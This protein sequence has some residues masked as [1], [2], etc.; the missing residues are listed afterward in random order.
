MKIKSVKIKNFRSIKDETLIF[1]ENWLVSIIWPNNAWKSN[2]LRAIDLVLWDWYA[3]EWKLE[4]YDFY[5]WNRENEIYIQ[6]NFT[7]NPDDIE[8]F[9][10]KKE[11]VD[12]KAKMKFVWNSTEYFLSNEK[13]DK[14]P[15]TY[16]SAERSIS[17][18]TAFTKWSLMWKISKS[19]NK[20]INE[21]QKQALKTHFDWVKQIFSWVENFS[22]FESDFKQYFQE[23]QSD[24]PY[25]LDIDFKAFT[26]NNYFKSINI[27]ATDPN[28]ENN[29]D[30]EELWDWAK[31]LT[32]ISLLRSYAKN[33]R[34]ANGILA[35]EEPEI[36][37]HPQARKHLYDI[38][39]DLANSWVQV[40]YTTHDPNFLEIWEFESIR[41]IS[42]VDDEENPL[43][44]YSKINSLTY[45]ELWEFV[46]NTWWPQTYTRDSIL[47]FYKSISNHRLSEWFFSNMIILCEWPTEELVIP[48]YFEK[49]WFKYNSQGI[50]V[51]Y[52]TWKW[53]IPKYWRLFNKF[54]IPVICL[55]D[56]DNTPDKAGNNQLL[57]TCFNKT[58]SDFTT[59]LN[60]DFFKEIQI[61]GWKLV[62][63]DQD[64][65]NVIKKDF[66]KTS[67]ENEYNEL[68]ATITWTSKSIKSLNL[69][70]LILQN[71]WN[72][73][74]FIKALENVNLR[75]LQASNEDAPF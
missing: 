6:V 5:S 24:S 57:C 1:P 55:F 12:Y 49:D 10:F 72:I 74:N 38:L 22:N 67:T 53:E 65:E 7:S 33:F 39:K 27:L 52:T 36:Y 23:M 70:N 13:K 26:P 63:L 54:W 48:K 25:K 42:K 68:V 43:R 62:I 60:W 19:F 44:K 18:D 16:L 69:V 9:C 51:L 2:F 73:P 37:L 64:I 32:I 75:I 71:Y 58:I 28:I 34:D 41:R 50:S 56:N 15:C 40:I 47:D 29:V 20:S 61:D 14:F 46:K 31:N 35:I 66:L 4:E 11:W 30:I 21:T 59:W 3:N 17:K 8:Y 45:D